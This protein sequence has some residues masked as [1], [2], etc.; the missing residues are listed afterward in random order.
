MRASSLVM[1]VSRFR[2]GEYCDEAPMRS[3]QRSNCPFRCDKFQQYPFSV[4]DFPAPLSGN[5]F[6]TRRVFCGTVN[7]ALRHC[8]GVH[9]HSASA[10]SGTASLGCLPKI[11]KPDCQ[12]ARNMPDPTAASITPTCYRILLA[13]NVPSTQ[14]TPVFLVLPAHV[15]VSTKNCSQNRTILGFVNSPNIGNMLFPHRP[16]Q[17]IKR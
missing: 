5:V 12:R 16:E 7:F 15:P 13:V 17:S 1:T 2:G 9:P 11:V 10:G 3:S 14:Q 6:P 4:R 8:F